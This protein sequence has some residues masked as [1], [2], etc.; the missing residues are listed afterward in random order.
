[1]LLSSDFWSSTGADSGLWRPLILLSYWIDGRLGGWLPTWFHVVNLI[2]HALATAAF[3]LLLG[4]LGAGALAVWLA[5]LWFAIM[6]VHVES[7]AWIS[8]RTDVWCA[9]F[10][11]LALWMHERGTRRAAGWWRS[12]ALLAFAAALLSK[13]A[14][15]PLVG[16]LAMLAWRRA[17]GEPGAARRAGFEVAPYLALAA[18]WLVVHQRIAPGQL[19]VTPG[20]THPSRPELVWTGLATLPTYLAL[21]LP[22]FPQGPDRAIAPAHSPADWRVAAGLALHVVALLGLWRLRRDRSGLGAA[23]ML[24]WLPLAMIGFVTVL[25]GVIFY[26]GRNLYLSSAGA[27]WLAGAGLERLW[28]RGL[29]PTTL[30]RGLVPAAFVVLVVVCVNQTWIAM[31]GWRT[32]ETMYRAM[33]ATQ[34]KNPTGYVGLAMVK[35]GQRRDAAALEA[36]RHAEALDST[37]QEIATC[38]AAIESRR[39]NW[40]AVRYWAHTARVR[41]A[42]EADAGLMEVNALQLM[43]ELPTARD[44]LDTLMRD[45][46]T[47]PDVAA[48]FGRQMLLENRPMRAVK[49]LRYAAEWDPQDAGLALLLG[50]AYARVKHYEEARQELRRATGLEPNNVEAWL[51]LAAVCHLLG[52]LQERDDALNNANSLPGAD[53][54]QI[55]AMWRK[56]AGIGER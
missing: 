35:I 32:D 34:P 37:R 38:R 26:G 1:M 10:G 47:D 16:V 39:G 41:G 21:L 54:A 5:A 17:A 8:G 4:E 18:V 3:A 14:A 11:L 45:H 9:L 49:P 31:A 40:P 24:L 28:Q 51:R 27:A 20:W 36:L 55:D 19:A 56:M 30:P 46:K 15:L 25:R 50:D 33:I 12:G 52:A 42:L 43:A 53:P 22:G 23:L 44:L 6:P 13:E 2:S 7:V 29:A 48:A